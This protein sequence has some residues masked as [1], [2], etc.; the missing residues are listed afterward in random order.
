M[1]EWKFPRWEPYS[2]LPEW[3]VGA[4]ST[5][6]AQLQVQKRLKRQESHLLRNLFLPNRFFHL[7]D[8]WRYW[9]QNIT[10]TTNKNLSSI[11]QMWNESIRLMLFVCLIF[12]KNHLEPRGQVNGT[13][14][15]VAQKRSEVMVQWTNLLLISLELASSYVILWRSGHWGDAGHTLQKDIQCKVLTRRAPTNVSQGWCNEMQTI[16]LSKPSSI[17]LTSSLVPRVAQL[18]SWRWVGIRPKSGNEAEFAGITE[19]RDRSLSILWSYPLACFRSI[20]GTES[21]ISWHSDGF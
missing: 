19:T 15:P 14:I 5:V 6:E 2:D 11:M 18:F 20:D 7:E 9:I 3:F 17:L 12:L 1:R 13:G 4:I 21:T 10:M 8:C 16:E